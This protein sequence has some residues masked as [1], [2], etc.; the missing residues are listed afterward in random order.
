MRTGLITSIVVAT[1]VAVF[2]TSAV[3]GFVGFQNQANRHEN[4]IKAQYTANQNVYDNGY[5]KVLEVAQIPEAYAAD[6]RNLYHEAITGRYG[7]QG[8]RAAMQWIQEQNPN[9]DATLYRQVQQNIEI[10]RND[11]TATQKQLISYKQ[12]YENFL[13]ANTSSRFYN[14]LA[15]AFGG[16]YPHIDLTKFDIVTSARTEGAFQTKKDEPLRLRR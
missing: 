5:K 7:D 12:E 6:F 11:F 2:A 4:A 8:S 15:S 16:Q 14:W 9:I 3:F 13:I 10:F 1:L